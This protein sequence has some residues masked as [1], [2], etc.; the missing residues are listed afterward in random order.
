MGTKLLL[1]DSLLQ[2][3]KMGSEISA[4]ELKGEEE[5]EVAEEPSKKDSRHK[6][7]FLTPEEAA[8]PSKVQLGEPEDHPLG[9]ILPNGEINWNCPCLGGMAIGPC[10]IE[11]REAISWNNLRGCKGACRA[12]LSCLKTHPRRRRRRRKSQYRRRRSKRRK[13]YRKSKMSR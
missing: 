10:G 11:F 3:T 7:V 2:E 13:H 6:T 8:E 4:E 12:F 1:L 5:E 9:L